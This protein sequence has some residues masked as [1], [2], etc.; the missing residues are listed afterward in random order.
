MGDVDGKE[1][2]SLSADFCTAQK[3][4][5]GDKDEFGIR[6]GLKQMGKAL[7]RGM[8]LVMSLWDDNTARMLWLD[9]TYPVGATGPGAARGPCDPSTGVPSAT[10]TKYPDSLVKYMNIKVGAIGTTTKFPPAPS[11]PSP[12]PPGPAPAPSSGQCC[13]GGCSGN[14]Q[15]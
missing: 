9:S 5:T 8:V 15:G 7:E 4:E 10:R 12:T 6:G 3:K 2:N 14:C 1:Y 13:Y 11:P